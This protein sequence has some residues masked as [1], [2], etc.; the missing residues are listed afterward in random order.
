MSVV[1]DGTGSRHP[2]LGAIAHGAGLG[3]QRDKGPRRKE[4]SPASRSELL[5]NKCNR[6][7]HLGI[8]QCGPTGRDHVGTE[9]IGGSK[10]ENR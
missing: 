2:A 8:Q 3:L 1:R 5:L 6:G 10:K 4:L 7:G 9:F